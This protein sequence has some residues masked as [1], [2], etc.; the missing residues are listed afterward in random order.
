MCSQKSIP[1]SAFKNALIIG[2]G[3]FFLAIGLSF[4]SQSLLSKINSILP[5]IILLMFIILLGILFDII[6]TAVTKASEGPLHAKAATKTFGAKE[7][8]WLIKNADKVASYCNDVIGDISGTLSGAIGAALI[9]RLSMGEMEAIEILF[10]TLM[11]ASIAGLTIGGK[12]YGK[13]YALKEAETIIFKVGKT[14]AFAQRVWSLSY[15]KRSLKRG[16]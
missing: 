13:S 8:V 10:N 4:A 1:K 9:V 11:T 6:G 7:A 14:I 15:F 12:A 5:A 16:R 3:A 2:L